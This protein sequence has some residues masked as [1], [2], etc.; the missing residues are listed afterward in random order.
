MPFEDQDL[1]EE[2]IIESQEHLGD[3]E[4]QLLTL[5][6]Q[7]D[8]MDTALVNTV[9]RAIHSIKGAAGFLGLTTLE[10]LAHREEEVLNMLR[11]DELSPTSEVI[12]TLLTATDRIKGLLDDIENSNDCDVSSY[13]EQLEAIQ[14][15]TGPNV[16]EEEAESESIG[17]IEPPSQ[18]STTEC[19]SKESIAEFV[20]ESIENLEQ[21]DRD[22]FD[23]EKDLDN[24]ELI[25]GVFRH[26][27]TV[28][29]TAGFLNFKSIEKLSHSTEDLLGKVRSGKTALTESACITLFKA[30]ETIRNMVKS[31]DLCGVEGDGEYSDL[32]EELLELCANESTATSSEAA[33]PANA[34]TGEGQTLAPGQDTQ[35]NSSQEKPKSA[36]GKKDT[37]NTTTAESTIRVDVAA[38]DQL[39]TSVGELVLARNQI[40]QHV[41][42]DVEGEL[43]S[44]TQRLNAV[45]SEL[46]ECVMKTR[47]QPIG[48]AWSKFPR[49]VRDLAGVC[50]KQVRIEMEGKETEL[51]K[52]I[53]ES[54]KDPL[55]HLVRNTVDHGIEPP[56]VRVAN[57]KSSE[58]CLRLSAYH[59]S[60]QVNIE[61]SDDGAG[62]NVERV[63][64]KA[65]ERQL[66]NPDQLSRM[67]DRDVGNLIFLPGFSTAQ[68]VS[69]VSGRGVGMDV[70][71]TNIEKIG[72]TVDLQSEQG[73]GTTIKIKIPLTLAIVPALIASCDGNR[74]A[75]PQVN[76]L[77]LVRLDG[78]DA[79]NT[80]E[81]IHGVPVYRLRGELLPLVFLREQL[82]C[83]DQE[84]PTH[85]SINIVVLRAGARQFGLI[86][87]R[88]SDTEE[89]VVKP[90]S[91][92]IKHVPIYSGSTIM[93][94]GRVAL[95]LDVLGLAESAN[96]VNDDSDPSLESEVDAS[97][98]LQIQAESYIVVSE[99]SSNRFAIPMRQV[100][101]LERISASQIEN[102]NS[103]EVIKYRDAI[104]PLVRLSES[105]GLPAQASS[106]AEILDVVVYTENNVSVG[107]VVACIVDIVETKVELRKVNTTNGIA[108]STLMQDHVTDVLNLAELV[109]DFVHL[110]QP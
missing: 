37:S 109:H 11:N 13:V 79:E 88:I 53:I 106:D 17:E 73:V 55:T 1:L 35:K 24:S 86:V 19:A 63:K 43:Y 50:K 64:A 62:I 72:G 67:A 81:W 44:T 108:G 70:V 54:I 30:V 82:A 52:T 45:T 28:K 99:A 101:R 74:Y 57:N 71:K 66:V 59:E 110:A 47:M 61:I 40:L 2:F 27:H 95:I 60:G 91:D 98:S 38:L 49:L 85:D 34:S 87:D 83:S 96:A 46:Q 51:D 90:L 75:V 12:N 89:I 20:V 8:Q 105:V 97:E 41:D 56:D 23:L 7:G 25:N 14:N 80:I 39:M 65:L 68:T 58:G 15:S 77:E 36:S 26:I 32:Y 18:T 48:N 104:L 6:S 5:E 3:M 102:T 92:Q 21:V 103:T 29:G 94:D 84:P 42:A 78:S 69:N 16:S 76:L 33:S 107:I 93:G 100:T 4:N 22:L 9:F 31:I 10:R